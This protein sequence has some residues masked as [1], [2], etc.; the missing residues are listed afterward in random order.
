MAGVKHQGWQNNIINIWRGFKHIFAK[1]FILIV[2]NI[3]MILNVLAYITFKDLEL[4]DMN[5]PE[6]VSIL[7]LP[8]TK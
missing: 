1:S 7:S 4:L 6:P 8:P 2:K 3:D 5:Y